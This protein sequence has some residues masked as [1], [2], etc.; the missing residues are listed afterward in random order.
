MGIGSATR[1][2][3][4]AARWSL[5]A[6]LAVQASL[7]AAQEQTSGGNSEDLAKQLA[8]PIA[9]L[10]SVPIQVNFDDGFGPDDDGWRITTNVQPVVPISVSDDWNM[11]S[12]TIV[13]IIAQEGISGPG[14]SE[15]GLGDTFQSLFFSPKEVGDSGIIWGVGPVF[16]VPTATDSAL[17]G[18]KWGAGP[19]G[20]LLKQSGPITMGLLVN[21][22]WSIAGDDARG[23]ISQGFAQPFVTYVTPKGTSYGVSSEIT[24]DW[25]NDQ[26]TVP[27]AASISQL[28]KF[29]KQPVQLTAGARYY[30][31]SAPNGPDWGLRAAIT[32]LFPAGR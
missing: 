1:A 17:G 32:F 26:A 25:I 31:E 7:A 30:V 29:G 24:Y 3:R 16:L 15:F 22:V 6:P 12:R 27:I 9:S 18:E 8:N 13:P 5:V 20:V 19:T 28:T 23:D 4:R 2:M 11:M 21:Q 14:A 10:I